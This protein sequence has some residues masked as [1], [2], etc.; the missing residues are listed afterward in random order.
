[1]RL[2]LA[3]RDTVAL[4]KAKRT[5]PAGSSQIRDDGGGVGKSLDFEYAAQTSITI[6]RIIGRR[7]V[8]RKR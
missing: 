1:M 8:S 2:L 4:P 6:G 5:C 3:L 7:R